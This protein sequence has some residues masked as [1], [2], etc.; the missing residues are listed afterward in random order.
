MTK[1]PIHPLIK[2]VVDQ[3][4]SIMD[5]VMQSHVGKNIAPYMLTNPNHIGSILMGMGLGELKF[6]DGEFSIHSKTPASVFWDGK[7]FQVLVKQGDK[8]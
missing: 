5:E 3:I 1:E 6:E 2:E 8:P 4:T 7:K